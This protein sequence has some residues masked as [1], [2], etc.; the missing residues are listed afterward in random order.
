MAVDVDS[1]VD[2]DFTVG[3]RRPRTNRSDFTDAVEPEVEVNDG[4]NV[5]GHVNVKDSRQR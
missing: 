3:A 4:L 1:I 5:A 2:V